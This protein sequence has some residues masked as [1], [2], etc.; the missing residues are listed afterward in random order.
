MI[1]WVDTPDDLL[2]PQFDPPPCSLVA[3]GCLVGLTD[4]VRAQMTYRPTGTLVSD[5]SIAGVTL[6]PYDARPWP[7]LRLAAKG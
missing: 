5:W 1:T 3:A 6:L 4:L 7:E 2:V